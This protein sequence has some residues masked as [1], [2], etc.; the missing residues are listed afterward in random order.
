MNQRTFKAEVEEVSPL[1]DWLQEVLAS[2]KV[3]DKMIRQLQLAVEEAFVNIIHHGHQGKSG[4]IA[5]HLRL[6]KD[7]MG[8]Q[9]TIKDQGVPYDLFKDLKQINPDATISSREMG[10]LGLHFIHHMVDEVS[11]LRDNQHN[12]LTLFKHFSQK[13]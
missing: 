3:E 7:K 4:E 6:L 12:T 13:H 2:F 11:Y 8:L 5:I 9:I 1:L 10:G